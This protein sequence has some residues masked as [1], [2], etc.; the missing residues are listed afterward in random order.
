MLRLFIFAF[1]IFSGWYAWRHWHE[2]T[3]RRP[4]HE[5][6]VENRSG[7]TMLRVRLAVG[8]Q[9]F[10]NE[11]IP[12]NTNVTIPFLVNEDASFALDWK[13]PGQEFDQHWAGGFVPRGPMVQR[14]HLAVDNDGAVIYQAEQKLGQ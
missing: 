2:I 12:D 6:I 3:D 13:W 14:H 4:K 9:T 7:R 5:A 1:L 8:G 11:S 10:V